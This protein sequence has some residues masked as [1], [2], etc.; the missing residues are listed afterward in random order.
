MDGPFGMAPPGFIPGMPIPP[1]GFPPPPFQGTPGM[2]RP[3]A[4]GP[5]PPFIAGTAVV[6]PS[7]PPHLTGPPQPPQ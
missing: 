2:T 5:P 3:P 7:L 1:R 6:P 4:S